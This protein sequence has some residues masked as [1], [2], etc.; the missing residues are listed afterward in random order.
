MIQ[1]ENMMRWLENKLMVVRETLFDRE[2]LK[3]EILKLIV[4][5]LSYFKS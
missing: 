3:E 1:S 4:L 2:N 5:L